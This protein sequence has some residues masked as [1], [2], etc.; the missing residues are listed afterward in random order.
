MKDLTNQELLV[1]W[2]GSVVLFET[3]KAYENNAPSISMLRE[4]PKNDIEM[5][6]KMLDADLTIGTVA[7]AVG[8]FFTIK[9]E[10]A[11]MLISII[12]VIGALSWWRH[13]ILETDSI[14]E[15]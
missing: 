3:W 9:T 10:D 2:I 11:S 6:Q 15:I 8:L 7:I 14:K 13:E 4:A 12:I 5:K 1:A